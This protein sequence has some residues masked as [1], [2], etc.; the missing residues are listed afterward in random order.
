MAF[1]VFVE[2]VEDRIVRFD[3][4]NAWGC[5]ALTCSQLAAMVLQLTWRITGRV[6]VYIPPSLAYDE[7]MIVK[8]VE[9]LLFAIELGQNIPKNRLLISVSH[10]LSSDRMV[11]DNLQ[12]PATWEGIQAAKRLKELNLECNMTMVVTMAQA[13]ACAQAKVAYISPPIA[14]VGSL[15]VRWARLSC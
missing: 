10:L 7:E 4:R 12:M 9:H 3:R 8:K 6:A 15:G 2:L 13:V 5:R 1:P 14:A 11:L